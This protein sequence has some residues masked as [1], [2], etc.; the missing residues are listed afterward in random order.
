MGS[1]EKNEVPANE[2][3][4]DSNELAAWQKFIAGAL[5]VIFTIVPAVFLVSLWPDKLPSPKDD[6]KPLYHYSFWHMHTRLVQICDTTINCTPVKAATPDSVKMDTA[7]KVSPAADSG[8]PAVAAVVKPTA[9]NSCYCGQNECNLWHINTILLL[10]VALAGFLG[11]MIHIATS[12]TNFVGAKKFERSWILWYCVKPFTAASLA[13][14]LYFVFRGGFL[15]MSDDASNINL[16]GV[17]TISL[18]AGLFTDR[19]TQKLK[20]VF[21]VLFQPKE[22]RPNPMVGKPKIADI[23]PKELQKDKENI[24]KLKGENLENKKLKVTI[25]DEAVALTDITK[26]AATVKYSIPDSQKDKTIFDLVVKDEEGNSVGRFTLKLAAAVPETPTAAAPAETP[27]GKTVK[28]GT[29]TDDDAENDN[30]DI[31]GAD[32]VIKE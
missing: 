6:I 22:E 28:P 2:K 20:E 10:L 27:G 7:K 13:V 12:F 24:I 11:N 23:N 4:T 26:D 31:A 1:E 18:L 21:E 19:A 9:V 29:V 5:L 30:D 15:N 8:K 25:N 17:M 3:K 16:Y 14:G 32:P